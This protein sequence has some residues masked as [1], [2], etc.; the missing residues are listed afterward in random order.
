M[1]RFTEEL[2]HGKKTEENVPSLMSSRHRAFHAETTPGPYIYPYIYP[3]P[4][5]YRHVKTCIERRS[6]RLTFGGDDV[7]TRHKAWTAHKTLECAS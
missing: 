3:Y 1:L 5:T 6:D 2:E 7:S 4:Y